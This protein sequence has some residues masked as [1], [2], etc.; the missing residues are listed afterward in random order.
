MKK[1]LIAAAL[2]VFSLAAQSEVTVRDAWARGTMPTQRVTGVFMEVTSSEDAAVVSVASPAA[3]LAEIHAMKTENGV[4]KMRP[5]PRLDLPAGKPVK[6]APRGAHVMLMDLRGQ[7]KPG[8]ALPIV[9][10]VEGKNGRTQA[11]EVRA[12]V[13]DLAAPAPT[14]SNR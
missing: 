1:S 10:K 2:A 5:L 3:G 13:I 6:L 11:I 8:D 4:M 7:L 14:G 12:R 9:L